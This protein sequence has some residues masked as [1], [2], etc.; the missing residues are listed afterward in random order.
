[1]EIKESD[2]APQV[3]TISLNIEYFKNITVAQHGQ[4]FKQ[5]ITLFDD[6]DDDVEDKFLLKSDD[7][8][9]EEDLIKDDDV[10]LPLL[11]LLLMIALN[12]RSIALFLLAI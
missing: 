4:K 1:M 8:D 11:L 3:G 12:A 9:A 2:Y 5:L 7:G 6:V 10:L